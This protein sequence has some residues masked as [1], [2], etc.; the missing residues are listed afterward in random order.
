M[1]LSAIQT[2]DH[3]ENKRIVNLICYSNENVWRFMIG[4]KTLTQDNFKDAN[5]I[6]KAKIP[7]P[8]V[9][10]EPPLKGNMRSACFFIH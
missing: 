1:D 2:F 10:S 6:Q 7:Y 8:D 4:D 9:K 5:K 3:I